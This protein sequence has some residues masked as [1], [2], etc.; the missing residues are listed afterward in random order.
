[1]FGRSSNVD[2]PLRS[3]LLFL[4]ACFRLVDS[5]WSAAEGGSGTKGKLSYCF[6]PSGPRMGS[7]SGV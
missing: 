4:I 2:L 5:G 6:F 3:R 7:L 1:M